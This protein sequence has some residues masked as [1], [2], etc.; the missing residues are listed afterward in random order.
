MQDSGSTVSF[1]PS[2]NSYSS[3]HLADIAARVGK[4]EAN[5]MVTDFRNQNDHESSSSSSDEDDNGFEFVL[6]RQ[7]PDDYTTTD[8]DHKVGFPIFPLFDRDLLLKYGN[9]SKDQSQDQKSST[10]RLQLKNLFIEDRDPPSSSSS[11]ADELEG[12]LPETYCIWTPQKSSLLA[13]P[14]ASPSRCKKSNSTG[15][16]S[17]QRWRLRD[18]LHLRRSSSDGKE[19]FIFLNPDNHKNSNNNVNLG[20]KKEEKFE[21]GKI[22]ATRAGKAKEKVSAHEV[23]Y[24]RNKALK[25]G[26]KRKS[27][28]PYRPELVGFFANVNG[29]GRNF[30]PI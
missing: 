6:V 11:E 10:V 25:E 15:S 5:N 24:V 9:E 30:S 19:S 23:F 13:S 27:Y 22:V 14:S 21:K 2:F 29:L 16:S 8:G 1:C 3:D 28:L 12:I 26:D 4:E 20:K 17:K 18:L 7:D